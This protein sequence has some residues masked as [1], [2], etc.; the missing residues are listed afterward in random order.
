MTLDGCTVHPQIKIQTLALLR[1]RC[2]S[3]SSVEGGKI[4]DGLSHHPLVI[5]LVHIVLAQ[6]WNQKYF[7]GFQPK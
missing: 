7:T 1:D 5:F 4:M 2:I 6:M 3:G